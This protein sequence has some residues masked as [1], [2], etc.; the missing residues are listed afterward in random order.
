M[1]K[2][3]QMRYL[4]LICHDFATVVIPFFRAVLFVTVILVIAPSCSC[5]SSLV[6]VTQLLLQKNEH[7]FDVQGFRYINDTCDAYKKL[8]FPEKLFY[9]IYP[10]RA[11]NCDSLVANATKN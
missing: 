5:G 4:L 7:G 6:L 11:R 8:S 3:D 2:V 9:F 1:N 10:H